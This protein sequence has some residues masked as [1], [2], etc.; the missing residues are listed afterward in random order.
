MNAQAHLAAADALAQ[1]A[2]TGQA[3][4]PLRETYPQF[5]GDDAYAVQEINTRR[6]LES[7]ARLIG[8]KVG[9]TARSVQQQL[10]VDQPDFGMLFDNM[11]FQEGEPIAWMRLM[12]PKV[13]AEIAL[14]LERDLP[15]P[16][17][18]V[19]D[20]LRAT[21]FVLPAIEVVGSRIADWNI[22][23]ID[24]VADNASSS[25][26]V[27]GSMPVSLSGLDLRLAGMV[28]ER[29]GEQ[30]SVGAGAAC[31]GHPMNAAVWLANTMASRNRPL[32]AGDVVLTGALGP[33][34]EVRPG[35]IFEARIDGLGSVRAVFGDNK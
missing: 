4:A 15:Q 3:I 18:T 2:R 34:V 21:A 17:V 1:A 35:D 29:R 23:F 6:Q 7:G 5:D 24:T 33:M 14:V 13:E 12:Q 9:L 22:R 31:L 19:A 20:M 32:M 28:M 16:G 10:G 25:A 11:A 30:V 26:F 27:L 8:R